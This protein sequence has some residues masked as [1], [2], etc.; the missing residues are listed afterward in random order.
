MVSV[1]PC[2]TR[3]LVNLAKGKSAGFAKANSG[4]VAAGMVS[5]GFLV[6][7]IDAVSSNGELLRSKERANGDHIYE[8]GPAGRR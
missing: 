8:R 3:V 1:F 5:C 7:Y 6:S 2:Q 4:K